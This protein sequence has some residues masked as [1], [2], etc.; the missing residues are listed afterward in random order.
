MH[1]L[2]YSC[3]QQLISS[4]SQSGLR[5]G[6]V[7]KLVRTRLLAEYSSYPVDLRLGPSLSS[8]PTSSPPNSFPSPNIISPQLRS[9]PDSMSSSVNQYQNKRCE[10]G[11]APH[12]AFH[13]EFALPCLAPYHPAYHPCLSTAGADASAASVSPRSTR[14][15]HVRV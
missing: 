8:I 15:S 3:T 14:A 10:R 11:S 12:P 9:I 5:C 4:V 1:T 7:V 6:E 13:L 2:N